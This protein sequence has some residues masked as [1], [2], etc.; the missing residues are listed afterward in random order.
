MRKLLKTMVFTQETKGRWIEGEGALPYIYIY[1]YYILY[2]FYIVLYML[3]D[4]LY[5][6]Y[7]ILY[8]VFYILQYILCNFRALATGPQRCLKEWPMKKSQAKL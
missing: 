8:M 1:I 5:M 3:S 6:I 2:I 4:M 7:G